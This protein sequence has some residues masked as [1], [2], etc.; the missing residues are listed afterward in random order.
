MTDSNDEHSGLTPFIRRNM[1][2]LRQRHARERQ[3]IGR[4]EK[5]AGAMTRFSGSMTFVYIHAAIVLAWIVWN[6]GVFPQVKSFDPNFI[7]L[8]TAASVEA[9]F[10]STFVLISQ[11]R[12]E[13]ESNRRDELELHMTLL[14]EHEITRMLSLV[15]EIAE[16]LDIHEKDPELDELQKSVAPEEVLDHIEIDDNAC[17]DS[18]S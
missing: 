3:A 16:K 6:A 17:D 18:K 10:L 9:I 15:L 12:S 8:A 11:N 7:I 13:K 4:E 2:I 1:D 5:I 14:A